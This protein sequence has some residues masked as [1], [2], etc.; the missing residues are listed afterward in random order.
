MSIYLLRSLLAAKPEV[1]GGIK[2]GWQDGKAGSLFI[3]EGGVV[4]GVGGGQK[5]QHKTASTISI[6]DAQTVAISADK[7]SQ[8]RPAALM[9]PSLA[10]F[11]H[12]LH[13][14][15]ICHFAPE[16]PA[17]AAAAHSF[18]LGFFCFVF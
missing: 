15:C 4:G 18:V 2:K 13:C 9:S 11:Y 8:L 14:C 10:G 12:H 5:K 3:S 6:T 17:A 16:A 7:D 1:L